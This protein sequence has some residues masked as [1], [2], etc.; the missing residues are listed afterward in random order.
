MVDAVDLKSIDFGREGSSPS[1]GTTLQFF[2]QATSS[3]PLPILDSAL[4]L[5]STGATVLSPRH[6]NMTYVMLLDLKDY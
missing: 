5:L 3:L 6:H 1:L 2:S 4:L